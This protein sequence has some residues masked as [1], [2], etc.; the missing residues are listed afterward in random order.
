MKGK[1]IKNK[2]LLIGLIVFF[3]ILILAIVL[4]PKFKTGFTG[5][6]TKVYQLKNDI[7]AKT[8]ITKDMIKEVE[9]PAEYIQDK[10]SI[11]DTEEKIV[12]SY[13]KQAISKNDII[14]KDKIT[15][16][17]DV[18]LFSGGNLLAVTVSTLSSSVA[19][20]I[21]PGDFVKVYAYI[22]S[23]EQGPDGVYETV[24]KV[25]SPK[26]LENI[27]VAYILTAQG[28]DTTKKEDNK[29]Q[30]VP[31]VVVFRIADEK[32]ANALVKLEYEGKIHLEKIN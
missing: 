10:N 16:P 11:I 8:Q 22:K 18:A 5:A 30:V 24:A 14:S 13:S 3:I 9:F 6:T 19:G 29:N 23:E 32:Q 17:D 2:G 7:P 4:F 28:Y 26:E 20:K 12:D 21:Y 27:E 15:T 25:V 1:G 31:N